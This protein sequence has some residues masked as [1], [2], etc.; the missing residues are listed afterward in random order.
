ML[1][2]LGL[3]AELQSKG[4]GQRLTS[5][6]TYPSWHLMP[7]PLGASLCVA[8]HG[9]RACCCAAACLP[10]HKTKE[11]AWE[12]REGALDHATAVVQV[13][14]CGCADGTVALYSGTAEGGSL[15][16]VL[17]NEDKTLPG[18]GRSMG[19][20][21]TVPQ[22]QLKQHELHSYCAICTCF[23]GTGYYVT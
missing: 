12:G 11:L 10:S 22:L 19:E 21:R 5:Y 9:M 6:P 8:W 13:L 16:G 17:P 15:L 2:L 20:V 3:D 1:R 4:C 18:G 7:R 14:A 23:V